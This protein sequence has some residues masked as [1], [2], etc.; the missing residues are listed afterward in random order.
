M[1][2]GLNGRTAFVS[3]G[4]GGIGSEIARQFADEGANVVVQYRNNEASAKELVAALG[5]DRCL[6]VRGDVSREEDV[7]A[8]FDAAR[9]RFKRI[10]VLV[11]CAGIWPAEAIP[12]SAMSAEQWRSTLENNLASAFL[13]CREFLRTVERNPFEDPSIVLVGSTAGVFGEAGHADYAA[14]KSALTAG[15]MYSLKNEIVRIARRGRVNAVSPGW[16]MTTMAESFSS[17]TGAVRRALATI[18]LRKVALP[19]D[20]A[21]AVLFLSSTRVAGHISGHNLVVSGGMEGR[22]LFDE[23]DLPH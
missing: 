5:D 18:P 20:I 17:D 13:C 19:H 16:T 6:A 1:D 7:V 11:C 10:D 9:S 21:S 23:T 14:S 15:L 3:G 2:L 22:K 4:S 12:L 8:V